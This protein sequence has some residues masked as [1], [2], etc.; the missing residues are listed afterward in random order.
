MSMDGVLDECDW[1]GIDGRNYMEIIKNP[2][3]VVNN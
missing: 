1:C 2:C 3:T